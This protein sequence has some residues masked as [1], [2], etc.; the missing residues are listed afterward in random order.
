MFQKELYSLYF[1]ATRD[2]PNKF[3]EEC[4]FALGGGVKKP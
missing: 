2:L 3:T 4:G 1:K